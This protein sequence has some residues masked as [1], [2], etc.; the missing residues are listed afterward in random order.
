M[1][2][3]Q[4]FERKCEKKKMEKK[5]RMKEKVKKNKKIDLK[6]INYFYI[7]LQKNFTDLTLLYI[8]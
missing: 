7:L 2:G 3:S 8:D 5:H 6:S 4:K 1:F